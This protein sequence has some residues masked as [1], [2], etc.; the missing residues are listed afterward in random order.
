MQVTIF[1]ITS[2][3][4]G[5]GL[6]SVR[7][8]PFSIPNDSD[9]LNESALSY[10]L[11]NEPLRKNPLRFGIIA[12]PQGNPGAFGQVV[13]HLDQNEDLDFVLVLGD[14]TD[15]GLIQEYEWSK[16]A[17]KFSK[18]TPIIVVPGNHDGL[19]RGKEIFV[20]MFGSTDLS[21]IYKGV[22]F[23]LWNNNS[24]EFGRGFSFDFI[25]N[26]IS[27]ASFE[28]EKIIIASHMPPSSFKQEQKENLASIK[29]D[30]A[31]IEHKER[32]LA[33]L[34]GHVHFTSIKNDIPPIATIGIASAGLWGLTE[35]DGQQLVLQA[36]HIRATC[37]NYPEEKVK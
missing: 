23:L 21:F 5:C 35:W 37:Q 29:W 26:G 4:I 34:H 10:L 11:A 30:S 3:L 24:L 6:P 20:R 31:M 9:L 25:Q 7:S 28:S 8:T 32:I 18:T 27:Q 17:I 16:A 22:R 13:K 19:G 12:D 1:I 2:F 36:C 33:S 14:I 15:F